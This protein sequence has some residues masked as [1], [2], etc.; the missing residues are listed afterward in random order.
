MLLFWNRVH[1]AFPE[2][3][4]VWVW[5]RQP[6]SFEAVTKVTEAYVEVG[7]PWKELHAPQ[8]KDGEKKVQKPH[9]VRP[10]KG[11]QGTNKRS[12]IAH[13]VVCYQCRVK[14]HVKRERPYTDCGPLEF[15][16]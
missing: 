6:G 12:P 13:T 16:G 15:C 8:T 2:T 1:R 4:R 9:A 5:R 3:P 11:M 7:C 14:G 10:R